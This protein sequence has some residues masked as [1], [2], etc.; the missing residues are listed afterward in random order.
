MKPAGSRRQGPA[1]VA[2]GR[3]ELFGAVEDEPMVMEDGSGSR[4]F[5]LP[6]R[7]Y[8]PSELALLLRWVALPRR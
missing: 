5:L 3:C 7:Y 4:H 8:V 6:Q 1:D 2:A